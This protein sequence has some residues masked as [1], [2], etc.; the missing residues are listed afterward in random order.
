[1]CRKC[2]DSRFCYFC[3]CTRRT[4]LTVDSKN[5]SPGLQK[6]CSTSAKCIFLLEISGGLS[7]SVFFQTSKMLEHE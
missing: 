3:P 2:N 7:D 6:C 4:G 5:V 1:M